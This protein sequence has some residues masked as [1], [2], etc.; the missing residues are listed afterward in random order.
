VAALLLGCGGGSGTPTATTAQPPLPRDLRPHTR[1]SI[2]TDRRTIITAAEHAITLDARAR[3]RRH[4]FRGPVLRTS[5]KPR[6]GADAGA[7]VVVY[8]CIAIAFV[9]PRTVD[10]GAPL[11]SGQPFQ[12][13]VDFAARRFTW[14]KF[15]P[16][17]GEGTGRRGQERPPPEACGGI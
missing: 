13:R 1:S 5:C 15:A 17:G 6:A 4:E 11:V 12:V 2:A 7:D 16:P 10:A 8:S 3:V 9:G 14:C